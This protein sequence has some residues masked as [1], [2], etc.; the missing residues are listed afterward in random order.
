MPSSSSVQEA[1][2][3]LGARLREL[4]RQNGL[5][6][7]KLAQRCGWTQS[8]V[9][10]IEN[11]HIGI[12]PADI[13]TW[14]QVCGAEHLKEDLLADARAAEE[15]YALWRTMERNGLRRANEQ[16]TEKW[17]QTRRFKAYSQSLIP[18]PLQTESYTRAVLSALQKRRGL[19]DDVDD[20]VAVRMERQQLLADSSRMYAF[21]LEETVLHRRLG[22]RELMLGQLGRLIEVSGASNI[23]IGIIPRTADRCDMWP[24]EDFWVFDDCLVNVELVSAY[25][26]VKRPGEVRQYTDAF[27]RLK[28]LAVYGAEAF[29]LI[30]AA[31]APFAPSG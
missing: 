22:G 1:R 9:S 14:A 15:T 27:T 29:S 4:R 21:L 5:T 6:A 17:Q 18:G 26:T 31:L 16:A 28:T 11:G 23:S 3:S 7:V 13:A 10:R 25:L 24:V 2:R 30:G 8:K 19:H 12:N 20:A